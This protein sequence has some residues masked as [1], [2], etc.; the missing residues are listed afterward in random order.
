MLKTEIKIIGKL[1]NLIVELGYFL[2]QFISKIL[3]YLYIYLFI[4]S[5]YNTSS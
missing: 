4:L 5:I 2:I 3:K 1:L